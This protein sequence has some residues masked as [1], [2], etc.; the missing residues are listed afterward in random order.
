MRG[1][2]PRAPG[3]GAG[4][5]GRAAELVGGLGIP[6]WSEVVLAGSKPVSLRSPP[7]A[8]RLPVVPFS[9]IVGVHARPAKDARHERAGSS[10]AA[11]AEVAV[12]RAQHD[13]IVDKADRLGLVVETGTQLTLLPVDSY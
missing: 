12:V 2:A 10:L 1:S 9:G 3:G 7:R 11:D 5:D 13:Q 4:E 8:P 6:C